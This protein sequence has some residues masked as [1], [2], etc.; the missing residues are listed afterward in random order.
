MQQEHEDA[1][2][3]GATGGVGRALCGRLTAAGRTVHAVGR[4]AGRLRELVRET[5]VLP[6]QADLTD[7]GAAE[8]VA[9]RLQ[10][11]PIGLAIAAIGGWY[12]AEPVR[13]LPIERWNAT[14]AS[15]LTTH[16]VALRSFA[17]V[18]GGRH[19]V[20]L[21][22]NGI[23]GH[24]PCQGSAAISVAGAAQS[25]L[26]DVA[27]AEGVGTLALAELFIDTPI[28]L[29]GAPAPD[30]PSHDIDEVLAAIGRLVASAQADGVVHR[31][32]LG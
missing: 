14:L 6:Y 24:Y 3:V 17:P 32:H 4:N 12:V 19:P 13:S 8:A 30:E 9:H 27:A 22:L 2:V 15:N 21:A 29:P 18:L 5:G 20:Y 1:L 26:L 25:M 31:E 28:A 16:F 10:G 11:A 23:A 7:L